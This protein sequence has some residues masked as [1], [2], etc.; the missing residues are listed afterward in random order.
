MSL[1]YSIREGILG[2]KRAKFASFSST[3]AM[4]VALILIGLFSLLSLEAQSISEWLR[5]RVGE[6]EIFLQDE[7]DDTLGRALYQRALATDGVREAEYISR[8]QAVEIFRREF[9]E[10]AEGFFDVPFLPASIKVRV[11][12]DYAYPDS[13]ESLAK[14]FEAWN[15]VDEATY[16]ESLFVRVQKNLVFA[17]RFGIWL[18]LLVVLASVFLVA[19][20]VR[21][22]IYARR[23]LIRTMKL[24]GATDSFIQ[25]PFIVEGILQG[26][27]AGTIGFGV[28]YFIHKL[29][30]KGWTELARGG[31]EMFF[32]GIL[33][34]AIGVL[35]G[36]AGS[37]LAVRR[38]LKNVALH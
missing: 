27:I 19:N 20:T 30:A 22:T 9:G 2:F 24:V 32:F 16:D 7:A 34:L 38:F 25:R 26:L 33:M 13:L 15:R 37:F 29:A 1:S 21:L 3:M 6:I 10:S 36:W 11:E 23:L 35:L 17:R 4:A 28:V 18:G 14:H 31:W 5:L 12:S 8:A